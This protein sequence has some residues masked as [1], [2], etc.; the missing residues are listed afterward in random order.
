MPQRSFKNPLWLLFVIILIYL[1][2]LKF[3]VYIC[4]EEN[5]CLIKK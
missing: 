2:D 4:I 3:M 5:K 1:C